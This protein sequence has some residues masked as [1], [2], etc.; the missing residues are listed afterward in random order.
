MSLFLS[1]LFDKE[2]VIEKVTTRIIKDSRCLTINIDGIHIYDKNII[3]YSEI[4]QA[5]SLEAQI[6]VKSI[7]SNNIDINKLLLKNADIY[8]FVFDNGS[9]V[10]G[11]IS[12]TIKTDYSFFAYRIKQ[13]QLDNCSL[14]YFNYDSDYN[15]KIIA[16]QPKDSAKIYIDKSSFYTTLKFNSCDSFYSDNIFDEY[17]I[18]L[19]TFVGEINTLTINKSGILHD[20]HINSEGIFIKYIYDITS[21]QNTIIIRSDGTIIIDNINLV[22]TD[23]FAVYGSGWYKGFVTSDIDVKL[24]NQIISQ[25]AKLTDIEPDS[26]FLDKYIIVGNDANA[27]LKRFTIDWDYNTS[28]NSE[29]LVFDTG[30]SLKGISVC[31]L[32]KDRDA[33]LSLDCSLNY[34]Y[35]LKN[36]IQYQIVEISHLEVNGLNSKLFANQDIVII[37]DSLQVVDIGMDADLSLVNSFLNVDNKNH[38]TGRLFMPS[39]KIENSITTLDTNLQTFINELEINDARIY[40]ANFYMKDFCHPIKDIVA[41]VSFKN[42]CL[43]VSNANFQV[44]ETDIK[45]NGKL[46]N[47]FDFYSG[48][49]EEIKLNC[50][51]YLPIADINTLTSCFSNEVGSDSIKYN[52]GIPQY[53]VADIKISCDTLQYK[54]EQKYEIEDQFLVKQQDNEFVDSFEIYLDKFTNNISDTLNLEVRNLYISLFLKSGQFNF[55]DFEFRLGDAFFKSNGIVNNDNN[56]TLNAEFELDNLNADNILYFF[57]PYLQKVGITCTNAHI[58]KI[59]A[60]CDFRNLLSIENSLCTLSDVYIAIDSVNI[61][62]PNALLQTDTLFVEDTTLLFKILGKSF[63]D[64]TIFERNHNKFGCYQID[65][66]TTHSF[67]LINPITSTFYKNLFLLYHIKTEIDTLL[68]FYDNSKLC[69]NSNNN[70]KPLRDFLYCNNSSGQLLLPIKTQIK[71]SNKVLNTSK[72][73]ELCLDNIDLEVDELNWLSYR[74]DESIDRY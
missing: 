2:V 28:N 38:L 32:I 18:K 58:R 41:L 66:S 4:L 40:D 12:D 42:S 56:L 20:A 3:G 69:F 10:S 23:A 53:I 47:P 60:K 45:L 8:Y 30:I 50:E 59:K 67:E 9:N 44:G 35:R 5:E 7:L 34:D 57:K 62:Y 16:S 37:N 25:F 27:K 72:H 51:I 29:K 24:N 31:N 22:R 14:H 43:T 36:N 73:F 63:Y 6:N 33:N 61:S 74:Y 68:T 15:K 21:E 49:D 17:T 13:V 46:L 11:L 54:Y 71:K 19:D 70:T 39:L 55:D 26:L 65:Y 48:K 52:I 64:R 1:N